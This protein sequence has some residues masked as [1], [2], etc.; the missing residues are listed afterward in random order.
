MFYS[1]QKRDSGCGAMNAD[2]N[3]RSPIYLSI[4]SG[5]QVQFFGIKSLENGVQDCILL[6]IL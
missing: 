3:F 2:T 5:N 6:N 1:V 4:V